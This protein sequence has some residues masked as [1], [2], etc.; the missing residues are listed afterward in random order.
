MARG[1]KHKSIQTNK[2]QSKLANILTPAE[3]SLN[4]ISSV[5]V[6][7]SGNLRLNIDKNINL[8]NLLWAEGGWDISVVLLKDRKTY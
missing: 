1:K 7:T 5:T 8:F 2:Q 6:K 3:F 4:H